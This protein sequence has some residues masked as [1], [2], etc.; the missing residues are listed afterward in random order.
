MKPSKP[1]EKPAKKNKIPV[2]LTQA[3]SQRDQSHHETNA[4]MPD[5]EN[6]IRAREW[7]QENQK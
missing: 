5:E 6:V 4:A 1:P 2:F 3:I 7:V